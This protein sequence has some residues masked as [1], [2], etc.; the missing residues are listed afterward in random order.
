[1]YAALQAG[2]KP[3]RV[4]FGRRAATTASHRGTSPIGARQADGF[5]LGEY[6]G[7]G[8]R[9]GRGYGDL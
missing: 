3:E 1:M 4:T 9:G 8:M 5:G 2:G 7:G 6:G